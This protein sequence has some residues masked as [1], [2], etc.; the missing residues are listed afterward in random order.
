[1]SALKPYEVV[2]HDLCGNPPPINGLTSGGAK[3]VVLSKK[4]KRSFK[5]YLPSAIVKKLSIAKN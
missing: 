2:A 5:D 1:M 3:I 4:G